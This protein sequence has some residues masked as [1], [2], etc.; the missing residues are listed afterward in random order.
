[1][2]AAVLHELN[3]PFSIEDVSIDRPGPREVVL[4]TAAAGICHSDMHFQEGK[5]LWPMPC[6]LGHEGAGVVEAVGSE[7]TYVRPGD[8]VITCVS[9]FCGQCASCLRGQPHMCANRGALL[10]GAEQ[11]P[12]LHQNGVRVHQMMGLSCFAEQMLVHENAVV[13][14]DRDVPLDRAALI[15]CAVTTGVGAVLNTA[16]VE[17][18]SSVAV[19]GCGGIGLN[20]VQGAR[21]AGAA[22]IVAIDR[23]ASKLELARAF[24]ATDAIDASA[25]DPVEQ[26]RALTS[27][28]VDYSF[29][30]IGLKQTA[31]QCFAMLRPGGLAVVIGMIPLGTKV[32]IQGAEL[33]SEKRLTGT[34]MGSNRFRI[35]MPTYLRFYLQGRLNLDDLVSR[36]L[37]LDQ[38][39]QGFDALRA[40]EVARSVIVMS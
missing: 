22:R 28:G 12:A 27:G 32:E 34:N 8:H 6:V 19:V 15:G 33:L 21:L 14:I 35:D 2:K 37:R 9:V 29:E 23:I 11:P 31:E 30:A 3:K 5:Y 16:R 10:R 38:I 26:V 4:R 17:P 36:R 7:V 13:K 25:G 18:G 40:A 1:M 20:A 24:G 39:N